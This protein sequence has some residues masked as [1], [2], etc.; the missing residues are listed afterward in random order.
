MYSL[1]LDIVLAVLLVATIGYAMALNRKLGTLRRHKEELERLAATFS[2]S[3]ARAKDS[4][5]HLKNSTADLQADTAKAAGLRDDLKFL[6]DRGTATADRLEAAVRVSRGE[7]ESG[8]RSGANKPRQP[9][10]TRDESI[11]Q[12]DASTHMDPRGNERNA[13]RGDT[14]NIFSSEMEES[15]DNARSQAEK[16]L[17]EALRSVR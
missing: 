17:I 16:E 1:A 11:A 12:G 8:G 3:T 6:I 4:I 9:I 2:D 7:N 10:E 13:D 5:T 14:A 15:D